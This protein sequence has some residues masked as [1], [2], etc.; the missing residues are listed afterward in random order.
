MIGSK[1]QFLEQQ[2]LEAYLENDL[3]CNDYLD[4]HHQ[5]TI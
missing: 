1:E 3:H 2:Q 5:K 4:E